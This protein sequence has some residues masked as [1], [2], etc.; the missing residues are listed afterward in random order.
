MYS[1]YLLLPDM[2]EL[3][4]GIQ[5]FP[6]KLLMKALCSAESKRGD[7]KTVCNTNRNPNELGFDLP[8]RSCRSE[9]KAKY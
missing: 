6:A 1:C 5:I 4:P 3:A 7:S 8:Y 9:T 2:E